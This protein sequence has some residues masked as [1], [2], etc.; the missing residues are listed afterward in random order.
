MQPHKISTTSVVHSEEF[1]AFLIETTSKDIPY[2]HVLKIEWGKKREKK[3][4]YGIFLLVDAEMYI[5][6][7]VRLMIFFSFHFIK[8]KP[9]VI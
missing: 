8:A 4:L 7:I 2:N 3:R 1:S 9:T 6:L 5:K